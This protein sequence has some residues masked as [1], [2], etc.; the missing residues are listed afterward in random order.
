MAL[1]TEVSGVSGA[2]L[3]AACGPSRGPHDTFLLLP[4][5]C[6]CPVPF[7]IGHRLL[8]PAG[9]FVKKGQAQGQ[10]LHKT[11]RDTLWPT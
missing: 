6:S 1:K 4:P 10:S 3:A 2:P 7:V 5:S 9:P 11:S 8:N